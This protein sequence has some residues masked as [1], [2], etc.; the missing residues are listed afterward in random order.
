M[1]TQTKKMWTKITIK[2]SAEIAALYQKANV[3]I[4]EI[5]KMYP[6]Y[7]RRSIY[8]HAKK[9]FNEEAHDKRKNNKGA[10]RKLTLRDQRL[11]LRLIPILR[12][13]EGSFTAKRL[14]VEAGVADKVSMRTF[15]LFLNK[16]GYRYLRARKKGLLTHGDLKKR[17]TFCRRVKR[18]GLTDKFWKKGISLYLDGKGFAW[19]K[20]PQDQAVAPKSRVWR[21]P[22]EGLELGCT[23]KAGKA[24]VTNLNFM[25]G[26]SYNHGVVLCERY[27]GTITGDK[28]AKI[29]T[30]HLPEALK[31]SSN[32]KSRRILQDNCPRQNSRVA[33]R[34]IGKIGAQLLKIPARSPDI[35]CIEN[36]FA[37]ITRLL[38][39]QAKD[40]K[41]KL[42]TK[43]EFEMRIKKAMKDFPIEDVNK[44]IEF[45][46]K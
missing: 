12:R 23:A 38:E 29:V 5:V 46:A 34:A 24:G 30:D 28:F 20:N 21:K 6:Q 14:A 35:N 1:S 43:D 3:K 11:I 10:P 36:F 27:H 13:T 16:S 22:N 39:K 33:K 45:I 40:R 31:N 44:F 18:L 26:I 25:V 9:P 4:A 32:P 37:Q 15:R 7:S 19:K 2:H 17:L 8:Y 42:E 41:I